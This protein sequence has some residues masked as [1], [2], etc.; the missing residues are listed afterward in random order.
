MRK[1][2]YNRVTVLQEKLAQR[3]F[4]CTSIK[5]RNNGMNVRLGSQFK[6]TIFR[7]PGPVYAKRF[8]PKTAERLPI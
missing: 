2:V 3:N 4:N 8:N 5:K 1:N 6:A 7:G